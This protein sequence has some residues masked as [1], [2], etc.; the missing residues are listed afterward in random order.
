MSDVSGS[1]KNS[2]PLNADN[3]KQNASVIKCNKERS[4]KSDKG[5]GIKIVTKFDIKD[6]ATH[7][8]ELPW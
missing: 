5:A 3:I 4:M 7:K 8:A 1:V 2:D 6:A